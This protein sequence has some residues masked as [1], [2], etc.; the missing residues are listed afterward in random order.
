VAFAF[1]TRAALISGAVLLQVAFTADCVDGQ[2][3]RYSRQFSKLGGWLDAVFDRAKEYVVYAGLALGSTRGGDNAWA[4][5]G[6]ALTLQTFRHM[7]EFSY[8]ATRQRALG[9]VEQPPL[10][11]PGDTIR[12]PRPA[13][14]RPRRTAPLHRRALRRAIG[15]A[16]IPGAIWLRKMIAFP[17]GERFAAISLAA[18]F[19]SARLAL[20][21]VLAWGAVA[22]VYTLSGRVLRSLA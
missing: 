18:A 14:A 2:L 13:G 12:A 8:Q 11:H 6:A 19:G 10:E 1:G 15:E 5:A 4:L 22:A 9:S 20:T 17:I 21:V 16:R 3:A 7:L